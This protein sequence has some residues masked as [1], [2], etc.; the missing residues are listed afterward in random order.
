MDY[1]EYT[2]TNFSNY[3]LCWCLTCLSSHIIVY[4]FFSLARHFYS[5]L[6]CFL[7]IILNNCYNLVFDT[8]RPSLLFILSGFLLQ[9][10]DVVP[11]GLCLPNIMPKNPR[12]VQVTR[13]K[14]SGLQDL[15]QN[16]PDKIPANINPRDKSPK[17]LNLHEFQYDSALG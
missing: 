1:L 10:I 12:T 2:N 11:I 17:R 14:L 16:P 7:F 6:C 8:R 15:R 3:K 5:V 9:G 13:I 4:Y